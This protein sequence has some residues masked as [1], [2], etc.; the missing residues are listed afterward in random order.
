MLFKS[1]LFFSLAVWSQAIIIP[2]KPERPRC[3]VEFSIGQVG[4]TIKLK[5][6]FPA[7]DG[8][9]TG[10]H[11]TVTMRNSETNQVKKEIIQPGFKFHRE[12]ELDSSTPSLT[13]TSF[14]KSA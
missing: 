2:L 5:I 13:Q 3:L 6:A 9:E 4:A 7:I 10:E 8:V 1:L 14:T 11:F 12:E